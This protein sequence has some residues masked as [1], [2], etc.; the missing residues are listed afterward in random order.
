MSEIG[1]LTF[2]SLFELHPETQTKFKSFK[3]MPTS[4]LKD[5]DIFKQHASRVM[6]VIEKVKIAILA[7][8]LEL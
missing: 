3:D 7:K 1:V 4:D 8:I 5:N 6:S 2:I